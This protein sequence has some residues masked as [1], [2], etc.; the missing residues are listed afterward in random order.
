MT[1][2]QATR[3]REQKRL[4]EIA[5]E[6]RQKGYTV[7][8]EP[9]ASQLL[10][11][12][13]TLR[14]D[15]IAEKDGQS[16]V[17][18]V[19]SRKSL[20]GSTKLEELAKAVEHEPGWKLDLVVT[21]PRPNERAEL[22]QSHESFSLEEVA[23]RLAHAGRLLDARETEAALLVVSSAMEAA[24]RLVAKAKGR[25]LRGRSFLHD[26]KHLV[27]YGLLDEQD[28]DMMEKVFDRRNALVHGYMPEQI[29]PAEIRKL[30]N[31]IL[32]IVNEA[33]PPS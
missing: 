14:P 26:A 24:I 33:A 16:F 1:A 31:R 20:T 15:M 7:I 28:Y 11:F 22:E 25:R 3:A 10:K 29:E 18:E 27:A 4:R 5:N 8:L 30:I 2:D 9:P 23:T 19:K 32:K 17:V 13:A 21:N 12:L 6:Y